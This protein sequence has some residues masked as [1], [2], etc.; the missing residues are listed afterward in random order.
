MPTRRAWSGSSGPEDE[1]VSQG[2]ARQQLHDQ[3]GRAVLFSAVIDENDVRVGE[4]GGGAGLDVE[5]L[6]NARLRGHLG[7]E[8]LDRNRSI[9]A[10]IGGRPQ[11]THSAP[12]HDL[13]ESIAVGQSH[14]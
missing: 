7:V 4:A 10:E 3:E 13:L 11:L 6:S 2:A 12:A 8:Q 5:A 14:R 1:F 9:Q